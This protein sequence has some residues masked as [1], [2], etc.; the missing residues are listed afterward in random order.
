M[1]S[2]ITLYTGGGLGGGL[3]EGGSKETFWRLVL[4]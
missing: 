4:D 3:G 1:T 2:N